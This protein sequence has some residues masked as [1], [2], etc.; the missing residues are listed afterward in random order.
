M[1][2]NMRRGAMREFREIGIAC[3]VVLLLLAA[4]AVASFVF[5]CS[6]KSVT[7]PSIKVGYIPFNNCLPFFVAVEKGYFKQ[8][9]VAVEPVKCNDS[10]QAL[11]ALIAGQVQALAGITL[12]SY[13]AAEQEGSGRLKLFL[14]HYE[15][16]DE[17][18]SYLL[19]PKNS[20]IKDPLEL[21]GKKVGTYTG[22]SQLLYL[23]LYLK[24]LG[25]EADKDVTVIQVGSDLQIQALGAG[26]YDALF[27]VEPYGTIAVMKGIAKVLVTNPRTKAIQNPFWSAAA[28]VRTDY[29][30]Q[31]R[32]VVAS[33]Y[34]GLADGVRF[35]RSNSTAAKAYLPK[36]TPMEPDVAAKSGL[37][38]WVLV[39]E[40]LDKRG[41]QELAD[42]M[43]ANG[44]LRKT[45]N[46]NAMLLTASDLK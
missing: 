41:I 40:S 30:A 23:R 15:D 27:T 5:G 7:V 19:I 2:R 36:Y 12:S 38:R 16:A 9:G 24:K 29:F 39:D 28:G 46:A 18:Y 1:S 43:A 32:E 8:H 20:S 44:V 26:Q 22:V 3:R 25:L 42:L 13:W 10:S 35:I 14:E 11:N 4:C 31:N 45:V 17:P 21:K 6:R 33:L 37:Y 34:K